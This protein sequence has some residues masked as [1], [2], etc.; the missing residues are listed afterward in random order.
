MP[1]LIKPFLFLIAFGQV[2]I[3]FASFV[4]L[5]GWLLTM[6]VR[7]I[8]WLRPRDPA[9]VPRLHQ[10]IVTKR[11][12]NRGTVDKPIWES[13]FCPFDFRPAADTRVGPNDRVFNALLTGTVPEGFAGRPLAGGGL[14]GRVPKG[15]RE[16]PGVMSNGDRPIPDQYYP[17]G[18]IDW[19]LQQHHA[20]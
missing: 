1:I 17:G 6:C 12:V 14:L 13:E 18:S 11:L 4:G 2:A 15:V 5:A 10:R 16:G 3:L 8:A 9:D 20:I 7:A 19:N